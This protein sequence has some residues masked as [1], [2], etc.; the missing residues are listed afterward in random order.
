MS[1]NE[2]KKS[3]DNLKNQE[4][5]GENTKGGTSITKGTSFGGS[6]SVPYNTQTGDTQAGVNESANPLGISTG[7]EPNPNDVK[8][9]DDFSSDSMSSGDFGTGDA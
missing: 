1:N 3:I 6:N 9:L 2:N 7:F 8:P 5:D 4:I